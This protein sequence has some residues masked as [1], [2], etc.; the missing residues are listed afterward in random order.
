MSHFSKTAYQPILAV[1]DLINIYLGLDSDQLTIV[2]DAIISRIDQLSSTL[3][4][5]DSSTDAHRP[6]RAT[7]DQW[8][9]AKT[10]ISTAPNLRRPQSAGCQESASHFGTVE[11]NYSRSDDDRLTGVLINRCCNC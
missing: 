1:T 6:A 3:A 9:P 8:D 5:P 11:T 10:L 4:I 7:S 2:L